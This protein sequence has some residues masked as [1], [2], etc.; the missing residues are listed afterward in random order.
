MLRWTYRECRRGAGDRDERIIVR[1]I[2]YGSV[3]TACLMAASTA[4]HADEGILGTIGADAIVMDETNQGGLGFSVTTNVT[5]LYFDGRYDLLA[6]GL[7]FGVSWKNKT[8][9]NYPF[10]IGGYIAPQFAKPTEDAS[11]EGRVSVLVHATVFKKLGIG[12]G[13]DSWF[14]T[15]GLSPDGMDF[16]D[17][18]FITLGYGLTNET[19]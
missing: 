13:L 18:L 1:T 15:G 4:A 5:R 2:V 19:R 11:S 12:L 14:T 6:A 17:R 10:E 16:S 9:S 8:T 3:I 7:G